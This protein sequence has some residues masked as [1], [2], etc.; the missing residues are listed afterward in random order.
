MQKAK[1]MAILKTNR[2]EHRE[3]FLEAQKKYRERAI[4]VLDQQLKLAREGAAFTLRQIVELVAPED[5]TTEYDRAIKML[6]LSVDKTV[7]LSANEF[8][9]LVQD[10]WTWSRQWAVSNSGYISRN[11]RY[12]GKVAALSSDEL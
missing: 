3:I 10:V 6:E 7:T 2:A 12:Y 1:L 4:E 8:S 11:S 9:N 5:H